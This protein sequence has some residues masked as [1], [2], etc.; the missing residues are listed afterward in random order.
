MMAKYKCTVCSYIYDEEGEG[1]HFDELS[2][3]WKCTVCNAPR[4]AFE[5][6]E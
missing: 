3:D 1:T 5:K 2:R 6:A 4:E